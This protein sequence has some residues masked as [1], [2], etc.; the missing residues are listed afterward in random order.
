LREVE[1]EGEQLRIIKI[2]RRL[3][4]VLLSTCESEKARD[5]I[6]SYFIPTEIGNEGEKE[7]QGTSR[8]DRKGRGT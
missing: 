4:L 2:G 3:L 5:I 6:I 7:E 1:E 8:V